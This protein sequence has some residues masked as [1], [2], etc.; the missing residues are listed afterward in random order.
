MQKLAIELIKEYGED[1]VYRVMNVI[2][3]DQIYSSPG[4]YYCYA[5]LEEGSKI[6]NCMLTDKVLTIGED[7]LQKFVTLE[8]FKFANMN[9]VRERKIK[10]V[11][12]IYNVMNDRMATVTGLS[13]YSFFSDMVRLAAHG[14]FITD[15]NR[16]ESYLKIVD[17]ADEDLIQCLETYLDSKDKIDGV[18]NFHRKATSLIRSLEK[19]E[20]DEEIETALEEYERFGI[21]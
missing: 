20:T 6:R 17:S 14:H 18:T 5:K 10:K 7:K 21:Y 2:F 15:E 12:E 1:H 9:S 8:D 3:S 4:K 11:R 13:L 19:A 16:E